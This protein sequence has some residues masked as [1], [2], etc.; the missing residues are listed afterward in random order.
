M[1]TKRMIITVS[2]A[3]EFRAVAY[4]LAVNP[5]TLRVDARHAAAPGAARATGPWEP[6]RG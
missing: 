5:P 4:T 6:T 2:T 3:S 1:L